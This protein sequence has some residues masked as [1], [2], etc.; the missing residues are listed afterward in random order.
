MRPP[1]S[2]AGYITVVQHRVTST[3]DMRPYMRTALHATR[4]GQGYVPRPCGLWFFASVRY[5]AAAVESLLGFC[6]A[7]TSRPYEANKKS[8]RGSLCVQPSLV[9]HEN[10]RLSADYEYV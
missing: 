1:L 2:K 9:E 4:C 5:N 8:I 6:L 3:D 7:S 10:T